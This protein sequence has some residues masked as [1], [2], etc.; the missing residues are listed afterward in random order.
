MQEAAGFRNVLSHRHGPDI[1]DASVYQNL[2]TE[3]HWFSE[4]LCEIRMFLS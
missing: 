4:D 1:N 3:I 2:Q